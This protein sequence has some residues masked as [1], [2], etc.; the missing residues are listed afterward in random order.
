MVPIA[1]ATRSRAAG[2]G[3]AR[4]LPEERLRSPSAEGVLAQVAAPPPRA[5]W[6]TSHA[7]RAAP[8]ERTGLPRRRRSRT[9]R[10]CGA[11][12]SPGSVPGGARERWDTAGRVRNVTPAALPGGRERGSHGLFTAAA[13]SR[14]AARGIGGQR[15]RGRRCWGVRRWQWQGMPRGTR[16]PSPATAMCPVLSPKSCHQRED[17]HPAHSCE[18][19]GVKGCYPEIQRHQVP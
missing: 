11:R 2:S 15:C 18:C 17:P 6:P 1:L 14:T 7:A 4:Q 12:L 19:L 3:G 16:I 10:G 5:P 8:R 13:P 9:R